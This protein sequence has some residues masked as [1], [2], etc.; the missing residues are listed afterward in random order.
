MIVPKYRH[1]SKFVPYIFTMVISLWLTWWTLHNP[2]PDGYQNE[3][4]HVGNTFDIYESLVSL[5]WWHLRW[6]AYTSY[7]PWGFY[8][9]P[10]V[11]LLPFGK[12]VSAL[13]LSNLI[14][15]GVLMASMFRLAKIYR[16][17]WSPYL[18]MLTPAAFGSLTRFEPNFAN[19]AMTAFGLVCLVESDSFA[20]R[21]WSLLWGVVFGTALM[22]DRLTV[23]FYLGPAS[24]Y[25]LY[26]TN[27]SSQHSRR[28]VAASLFLFLL[29]TVAY[30][31]EFFIRHSGELLSQAPT[32]EIDSTGALLSTDNPLPHLYYVLSLL[33]SQAGWGIGLCMLVGFV[34]ALYD[35]A[36]SKDWLLI[37]S[38]LPGLLFFTLVAKK[39]VYYSF[40][41]LVPLAILAGRFRLSGLAV[42]AGLFV[43]LQQGVGIVP[44]TVPVQPRLP[45]SYV[46]P[47]YVLARPPSQQSYSVQ[48]IVSQI[49]GQPAE[50]IVFS[51][52]QGWYEGFVVLQ[53]RSHLD[54]HVRGVTAD[55]VGVWEF[56][57]VAEYLVW[58]RPSTVQDS[59]PQSGSVTAELISDHY[60]IS[61]LPAVSDSVAALKEDFVQV[62]EWHAAEDSIISVYKRTTQSIDI[63]TDI[64]ADSSP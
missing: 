47:S 29:C 40:P 46:S 27:W 38:V 48:E 42:V 10:M 52:D 20:N 8:A 11:F 58:V 7:W 3:F 23:L 19:L 64:D 62:G 15:L 63:D 57:S 39:Q 35:R 18:L 34:K 56:G 22:L 53:L 31:R 44:V 2:L 13:I 9:V 36:S 1:I 5:D 45:S 59:F 6:Y 4:L 32:G 37:Y 50:V 14:Y 12:S 30:Y 24:L 41:I 60:T 25:L 49:E 54:G 26:R 55:P 61:E 28:N 21:R 17:S 33:D 16:S 51:E 43:W